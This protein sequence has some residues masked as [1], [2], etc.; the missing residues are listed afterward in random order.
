[1]QH[2]DRLVSDTLDLAIGHRELVEGTKNINSQIEDIRNT[3]GM[4]N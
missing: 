3:I 2:I 4:V 1:M